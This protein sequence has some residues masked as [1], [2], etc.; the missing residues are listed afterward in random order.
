MD[1]RTLRGFLALPR[2]PGQAALF[3]SL[4]FDPLKMPTGAGG[5]FGF[6]LGV[7]SDF[8]GCHA[9]EVPTSA[10]VLPHL[11]DRSLFGF[12]VCGS[13]KDTLSTGRSF[14]PLSERISGLVDDLDLFV[15][16]NRD[17][18]CGN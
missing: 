7:L 12:L 17:P 1:P 9:L 3:G 5:L 10:V 2:R 4:V 8:L 13:L 18:R 16:S 14:R 11:G 15:C 6:A